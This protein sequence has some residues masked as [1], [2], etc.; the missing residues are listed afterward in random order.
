MLYLPARPL[1]LGRRAQ[2]SQRSLHRVQQPIA[3]PAREEHH[4]KVTTAELTQHT[5]LRGKQRGVG[6]ER[7]GGEGRQPRR[8]R[9]RGEHAHCQRGARSRGG[10]GGAGGGDGSCLCSV[11]GAVPEVVVDGTE[12]GPHGSEAESTAGGEQAS[13]RGRRCS[14]RPHRLPLALRVLLRANQLPHEGTSEHHSRERGGVQASL[15]S[16]HR[17]RRRLRPLPSD[18]GIAREGRE[19]ERDGGAG[20][21]RSAGGDSGDSRGGLRL[22]GL[23]AR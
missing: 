10:A 7:R 14:G 20:R 5:E 6:G 1:T 18:G 4:T 13:G 16:L 15:R 19:G 11:G 21:R 17:R 23:P 9:W 8:S 3:L 12:Q 22:G 2:R